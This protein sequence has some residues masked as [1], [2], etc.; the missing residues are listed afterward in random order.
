M[1]A[2]PMSAPVS[3]ATTPASSTTRAMA[4]IS[5]RGTPTT[6]FSRVSA[7]V[8][9]NMFRATPRSPVFTAL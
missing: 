8:L 7:S 6:A 1:T 3:A 4:V 5:A 9:A 2:E